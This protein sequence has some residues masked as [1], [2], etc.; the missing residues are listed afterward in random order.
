MGAIVD[1]TLPPEALSFG[2]ALAA[3]G[4]F[5]LEL[6]R[7]VP[8]SASICPFVWLLDWAP[9]TRREPRIDAFERRVESR[10]EIDRFERVDTVEENVLYRVTWNAD[11]P[12]F[13]RGIAH[14][15]GVI[16]EASGTATEWVVRLRFDDADQLA[17]FQQYCRHNSITLE[18]TRVVGAA[19][20][21]S[22]VPSGLTTAQTDALLMAHRMGYFDRPRETS[23]E[24]I[25]SRLEV[26]PQAAGSRI[27]R[28]VSN[29]VSNTLP[30]DELEEYTSIDDGVM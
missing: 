5:E 10:A 23:L 26:S 16:L 6:E 29:L 17:Q 18:L 8:V 22:P 14:S 4:G 28:G 20:S 27:R 24:E 30:V 13:V 3:I 15:D 21:R 9:E 25:A 12:G 19:E 11:E 2:P 7:V 1:L